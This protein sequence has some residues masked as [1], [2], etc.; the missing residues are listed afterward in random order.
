M[1][2]LHIENVKLDLV[3]YNIHTVILLL[4]IFCVKD[5]LQ[6]TLISNKE[7]RYNAPD[8]GIR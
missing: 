8:L 3:L 4:T 7:N 5:H 2:D 1:S 6:N